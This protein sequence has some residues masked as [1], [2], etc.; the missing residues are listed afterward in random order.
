M[1]VLPGR[2]RVVDIGDVPV[3]PND[4]DRTTESVRT[5][6]RSLT[7]RG[8]FPVLLGGDHYISYPSFWGFTEGLPVNVRHVGYIHIDGHL[9]FANESPIWGR[10]YHG[11]GAR[12]VSELD[13]V[14][15]HDMVWIGVHGFISQEQWST[16]QR[17]RS[18]VF[19]HLDVGRLGPIEVAKR[20]ADIAG[21]RTDCFYV[22]VDIDVIDSAFVPGTGS[23]VLGGVT[24]HHVREVLGILRGANVGAIDLMEVS[25]P[26]DPSGRS[27]RYAAELLM[28][29]LVPQVFDIAPLGPSAPGACQ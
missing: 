6:V 7:R 24:P 29:F 4:L 14:D 27:M 11:S 19:T 25:P 3:F 12:R 17:N 1:L 23:V 13:I 22:S 15:P 20:A 2:A 21:A 28:H 10:L 16:I 26:L 9:D 18:T 8:A 5:T